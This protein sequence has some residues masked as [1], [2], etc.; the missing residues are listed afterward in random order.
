MLSLPS[1]SVSGSLF[2]FGASCLMTDRF[3]D[4]VVGVLGTSKLLELLWDYNGVSEKD[5]RFFCYYGAYMLGRTLHYLPLAIGTAP[6]FSK[7]SH[8]TFKARDNVLD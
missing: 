2:V 1:G 6:S 8:T 5:T 4:W 3:V 7:K